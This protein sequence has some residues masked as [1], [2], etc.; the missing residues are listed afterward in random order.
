VSKADSSI[1]QSPLSDIYSYQGEFP[2][3]VKYDK[4]AFDEEKLQIHV[5]PPDVLKEA[6]IF[7][8]SADS[9]YYQIISPVANSPIELPQKTQKRQK[10]L[11]MTYNIQAF[12]KGFKHQIKPSRHFD[13]YEPKSIFIEFSADDGGQ[14]GG[15][16]PWI[17][18]RGGRLPSRADLIVK[19]ADPLAPLEIRNGNYELVAFGQG[20]LTAREQKPGLYRARLV[21][22]EGD[23]SEE[24]IELRGKDEEITLAAPVPSASL[25]FDELINHTTVLTLADI[26]DLRTHTEP[27]RANGA[28][29]VRVIII[30]EELQT[31]NEA[32]GFGQEINIS[33]S[34]DA[35]ENSERKQPPAEYAQ[36]IIEAAEKSLSNLTSSINTA[37]ELKNAADEIRRLVVEQMPYP[38]QAN[39]YLSQVEINLREQNRDSREI[40]LNAAIS[41]ISAGGAQY[42][43]ETA[44]G[45]YFL[46]IKLPDRNAASFS[47]SVLPA[48][49]TLLILHRHRDGKLNV[50]SFSPAAGIEA[51]DALQREAAN[52]LRRMELLQRFRIH[53]RAGDIHALQYADDL[54]RT[55]RL[56]PFAGCLAGYTKLS[57]NKSDEL[58]DLVGALVE[59]YDA[60]SDS[61]VLRAEFLA[62]RGAPDGEIKNEYLKALNCGIPIFAEGVKRLVQAVEKYNLE[63]ARVSQLYEIFDNHT[64]NIL[65]TSWTTS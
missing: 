63:H 16:P 33:P 12:A 54:S 21:L 28:S 52:Q 46:S 22:P 34:T 43:T 30:Q 25:S 60:L 48:R 57:L 65:W 19:S 59:L 13:L 51:N 14:P 15:R 3:L 55:E 44:P 42:E 1:Y 37:S 20:H 2:V 6:Q 50:F 26:I 29:G 27:N 5:S 41:P 58:G 40:S 35:L 10:L 18:T 49:T 53:N 7:V 17:K 23:I 62:S 36:A 11:P 64:R 8:S 56:D 47:V 9:N 39:E 31:E 45:N 24:I 61:H 38:A 4:N 32:A